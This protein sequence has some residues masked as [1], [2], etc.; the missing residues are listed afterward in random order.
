M[1]MRWRSHTGGTD[2]SF[3]KPQ[4]EI[5]PRCAGDTSSCPQFIAA[6]LEARHGDALAQSHRRH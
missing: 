1:A 3:L 6:R 5:I 4:F 2:V